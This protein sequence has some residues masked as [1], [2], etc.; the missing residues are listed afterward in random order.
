MATI[1][2]RDTGKGVVYDAIVRRKKNGKIIFRQKRTFKQKKLAEKWARQIE[3]K[4]DNEGIESVMVNSVT[5]AEL[6]SMYQARFR[7][8]AN[9]QRSKEATLDSLK[10]SSLAPIPIASLTV[11]DIMDYAVARRE[12]CKGSTVG[13]DIHML[14]SALNTSETAFGISFDSSVLI[15]AKKALQS[16]KV[17]EEADHRD[18]RP[19]EIE[20]EKITEF[21][22][23]KDKS[24]VVPML[25]ILWFAIYSAR[26]LGEIVRLRWDDLDEQSKTILVRDL[27]NPKKKIG[28][29]VL[30]KLTPE[31]FE[32]IMR[33][34]RDGELIFPFKGNTISTYFKNACRMLGINDLTFHDMRHDAT[35]R[36]FE[37]GYAIHE[38][39][40]FTLHTNWD[41]LKRYTHLKPQDLEER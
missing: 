30:S 31:A 13:N 23:K 41:T 7:P 32:I 18:R 26:R 10:L 2:R 33:Q 11:Q 6:I 35:S 28:N 38:V 21:L 24:S 5:V 40:M 39:A 8:I 4:I 37:R 1:L 15:K 3:S 22:K 25:D 34:P 20:L 12:K 29:H 36:L 14:A 27:K 9:W 17:I 19:S 16:S